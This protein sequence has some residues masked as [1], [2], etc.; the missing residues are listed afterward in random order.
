MEID[1]PVSSSLPLYPEGNTI[2]LIA[3]R[4]RTGNGYLLETRLVKRSCSGLLTFMMSL[5]LILIWTLVTL[6]LLI[7][8]S[9][10]MISWL[11]FLIRKRFRLQSSEWVLLKQ[12]DLMACLLCS[13]SLIGTL[14]MKTF[15]LR[16]EIFL[17][18]ELS[19]HTLTPI[20]LCVSQSP[21]IPPQLIT[22]DL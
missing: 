14:L 19:T 1:A 9:L 18:Q 16:C 2:E 4:A 17:L 7:F 21:K 22:S 12:L 10:A 8:W 11:E 15:W 20:T 13:L 3:S 5:L 6:F